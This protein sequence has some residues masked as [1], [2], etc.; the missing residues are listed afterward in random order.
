M[1]TFVYPPTLFFGRLLNFFS[2]ENPIWEICPTSIDINDYL[3]IRLNP[4]PLPTLSDHIKH[5]VLGTES[6]MY[7]VRRIQVQKYPI[8]RSNDKI[9]LIDELSIDQIYNFV[10]LGNGDLIFSQIPRGKYKYF[11]QL[12]TKHVTLARRSCDVRFAGE[13][14]KFGDGEILLINN[15]SGT[16]RPNDRILPN[17]VAYFQRLFPHLLVREI[18]RN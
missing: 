4:T 8:V 3:P 17:A 13:M 14:R 9:H 2:D 6:N 10:L 11:Y 5:Q 7:L 1:T 15:N 12:L 16:Y 18:S